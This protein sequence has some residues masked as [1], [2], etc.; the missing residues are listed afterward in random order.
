M[1]EL[2]KEE[3]EEIR[4]NPDGAD[5]KF[6]SINRKLSEDFIEEFSNKI[7][8]PYICIRQNL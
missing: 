5:W 7:K 8:W 4:K 6:I 1:E 2:S 3:I